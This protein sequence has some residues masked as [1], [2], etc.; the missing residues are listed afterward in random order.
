[1]DAGLGMLGAVIAVA[2]G[3]ATGCAVAVGAATGAVAIGASPGCAGVAAF[4]GVA[5]AFC[6]TCACSRAGGGAVA[7][8]DFVHAIESAN[9]TAPY[10]PN[11]QALTDGPAIDFEHAPVSGA[12]TTTIE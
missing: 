1:M 6:T 12:A 10:N 7:S 8:S 11:R 2:I 3:A 4:G 9:T 5:S